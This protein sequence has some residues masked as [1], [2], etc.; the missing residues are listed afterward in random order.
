MNEND[1]AVAFADELDKLIHRFGIE[2]ELPYSFVIGAM[3]M[4]IYLLCREAEED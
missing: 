2:F 4:K 1:Q 3:Q